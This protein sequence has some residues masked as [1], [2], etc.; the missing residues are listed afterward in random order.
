MARRN[1][2]TQVFDTVK[3]GWRCWSVY[4]H[5]HTLLQ[6]RKEQ[7]EQAPASD[8]TVRRFFDAPSKPGR[9]AGLNNVHNYYNRPLLPPALSGIF[10]IISQTKKLIKKIDPALRR[11]FSRTKE[12]IM[13]TRNSRSNFVIKPATRH[14]C[15]SITDLDKA[16]RL[17]KEA[18]RER[19]QKKKLKEKAEQIVQK[20]EEQ[21]QDL[22]LDM[23]SMFLMGPEAWPD[24]GINIDDLP[25]DPEI[26]D[27]EWVP[28]EY[29]KDSYIDE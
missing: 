29:N 4:G 26:E 21:K 8:D 10:S 24:Y 7:S 18:E 19:L 12:G 5:T 23:A 27:E 22:K 14:H 9:I 17:K 6:G 1:E 20:I 16:E 2:L 28:L 13:F 11:V 15:P 25:Y 3:R